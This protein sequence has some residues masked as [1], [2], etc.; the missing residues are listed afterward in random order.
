MIFMPPNA[1]VQPRRTAPIEGARFAKLFPNTNDDSRFMF[2][3]SKM[4]F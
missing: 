3:F 1:G 2:S 4:N